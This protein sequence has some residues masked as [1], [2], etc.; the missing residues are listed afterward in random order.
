MGV[1]VEFKAEEMWFFF[2][3]GLCVWWLIL[4]ANLTRLRD[5]KEISTATAECV[6]KD[7]SWDD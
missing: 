7:I 5:S 6:W 2:N 4:I 1:E 3:S